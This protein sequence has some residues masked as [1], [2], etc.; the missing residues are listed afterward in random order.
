MLPLKS[1]S[2]VPCGQAHSSNHPKES[3]RFFNRCL[4]VGRAEAH[5]RVFGLGLVVA[6]AGKGAVLALHLHD[7]Q[8]W[9]PTVQALLR[10]RL[11]PLAFSRGYAKLVYT[12][13]EA[14][15]A[16][17]EDLDRS[18]TASDISVLSQLKAVR[19]AP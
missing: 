6:L 9:E 14:D 12:D 19:S 13:M 7:V 11:R 8:A 5:L 1:R 3:Q 10:R 18:I 17:M 2:A 16:G 4:L 15:G